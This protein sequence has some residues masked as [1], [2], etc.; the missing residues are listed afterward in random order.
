MPGP[1]LALIDISTPDGTPG[2]VAPEGGSFE[3]SIQNLSGTYDPGSGELRYR[4]G[5]SGSFSSSPLSAN[6][7]SSYTATLPA[8]ECGE[9]FEFYVY[10]ETTGGVQVTLPSSAPSVVFAAPVATGFETIL[11]VDFE[12][13]PGWTVS[14]VTG[15]AVGGWDIA[16]PCGT[17]TRGAPGQDYDGSGQCYL[18]G[19]GGCDSNTDVDGGC[20]ELQTA[21]FSA[22]NS[23]GAGDASVS[24]ALWYDNTGGGIGADPSN[25]IM[26]VDISTNG[27]STWTNVET[28][29]PLD[30]RSSGGWFVTSFQVSSFGTPS[31]NC[32]MRFSACDDG[33]GSVI[34]AAVDAFSVEVVLCDAGCPLPKAMATPMATAWSTASTC[35]TCSAS[36]AVPTTR[37]R[38]QLRRD[39]RRCR[40][41]QPAGCLDRRALTHSD[42]GPN[43]I[44]LVTPPRNLRGGVLC[45][46]QRQENGVQAHARTPFIDA[47]KRTRTSTGFYSH[48]HLKLARL[49]I[50]PPGLCDRKW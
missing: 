16:S 9:S 4:L 27:G 47:Q 37:S 31:E 5:N 39:H 19:P 45:R 33:S 15:A 18:T 44:C 12:S 30:S 7:G 29:G 46:V 2:S 10:A 24:Y 8:A 49:P 50:P 6:G 22:V 34:E 25:D 36:G 17:T 28:I 3:V 35:P 11:D 32:M 38:L 41:V 1:D 23:D 43:L 48:Q 40:P 42:P 13:D 21:M 26:T 20:T 14:G